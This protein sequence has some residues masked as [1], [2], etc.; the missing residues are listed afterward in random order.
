[1]GK[2]SFREWH[3]WTDRHFS[4]DTWSFPEAALALTRV[5]WG[6][7]TGPGV[8]DLVFSSTAPWGWC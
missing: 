1:M 5:E 6:L 4:L 7:S 2:G 8:P 3:S